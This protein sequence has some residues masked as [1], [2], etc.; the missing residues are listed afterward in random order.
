MVQCLH[1]KQ[2]AV[3]NERPSRT[4]TMSERRNTIVCCFDTNSPRISAFDIHEW[5]HHQLQVLK[6]SVV[7]VQIVGIRR[8]VY[9]KFTDI[10]YLKDM[11]Q[12]TSGTT[13]YKH[14]SGEIS[15]V[16]LEIAGKGTRRVRIA[17]LPPEITG[18]TIRAALSTYGKVQSI[19]DETWSETYRYA[20]SNGI[21]VVT[22]ALTKHIPSVIT[23][24]GY[25][26]LTS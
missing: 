17:N 13:V 2:P 21:K 4:C 10:T 16:R 1:N 11:L 6:E 25:R 5:I 9:I 12:A 7:K 18:S 26:V 15:P 3:K 19:Q 14:A 20:V 24:A 8:Q 23:I 22:V